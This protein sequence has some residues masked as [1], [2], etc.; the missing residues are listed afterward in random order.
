M[1]YRDSNSSCAGKQFEG[2]EMGEVPTWLVST[3]LCLVLLFT[4]PSLVLSIVLGALWFPFAYY[5]ECCV[6]EAPEFQLDSSP[7]QLKPL[8]MDVVN[9][10]FVGW[11]T[12]FTTLLFCVICLP[13]CLL[14]CFI[15]FIRVSCDGGVEVDAR[16]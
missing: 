15:S 12:F 16:I 4:L 7:P 2:M 1:H 5:L 9:G 3:I 11:V 13:L 6:P 8:F 10:C 14:F